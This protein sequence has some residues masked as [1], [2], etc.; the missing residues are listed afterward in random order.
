MNSKAGLFPQSQIFTNADTRRDTCWMT[1]ICKCHAEPDSSVCSKRWLQNTFC[2]SNKLEVVTSE[3]LIFFS[4]ISFRPSLL[5]SAAR[6]EKDRKRR[7]AESLR[8]DSRQ[9]AAKDDL[10]CCTCGKFLQVCQYVMGWVISIRTSYFPLRGIVS[11]SQLLDEKANRRSRLG[12]IWP[13]LWR[14]VDQRM[15]VGWCSSKVPFLIRQHF[16]NPMLLMQPGTSICNREVGLPCPWRAWIWDSSCT[17][18][19]AV[20]VRRDGPIEWHVL[21][22]FWINSRGGMSWWFVLS[23]EVLANQRLNYVTMSL[24][25]DVLGW[26]SGTFLR[27]LAEWSTP[28]EVFYV[29][30]VAEVR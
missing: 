13:M 28:E 1:W 21:N 12:W 29:I 24:W 27:K 19:A 11:D 8:I 16:R 3:H 20:F 14:W 22:W 7:L 23:L 30:D 10:S 6:H 26:P 5:S 9:R 25:P 2:F 18:P 4:N 17:T 15:Q